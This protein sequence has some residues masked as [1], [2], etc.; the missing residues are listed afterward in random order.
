MC[1]GYNRK[2]FYDAI[3][4]KEEGYQT[5]MADLKTE[6]P[7]CRFRMIPPPVGSAGSIAEL[8]WKELCHAIGMDER[9]KK[10]L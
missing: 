1:R 10:K 9:E 8:Q 2:S 5:L 6:N 3:N 4:R 7:G